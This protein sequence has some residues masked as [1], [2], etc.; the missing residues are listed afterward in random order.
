M[1]VP[2][3]YNGLRIGCADGIPQLCIVPPDA[4]LTFFRLLT[5]CYFLLANLCIFMASSMFT[6]VA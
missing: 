6:Q 4:N 3:S 5:L 1:I 2:R